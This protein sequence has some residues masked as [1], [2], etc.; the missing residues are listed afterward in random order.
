MLYMYMYTVTF[1][2]RVWGYSLEEARVFLDYTIP[3]F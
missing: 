2:A 1:S 3:L